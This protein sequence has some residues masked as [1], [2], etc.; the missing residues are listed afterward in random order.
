LR[1]FILVVAVLLDGRGT[2]PT[3]RGLAPLSFRQRI[4]APIGLQMEER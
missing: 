2:P 3:G 4:G 1:W